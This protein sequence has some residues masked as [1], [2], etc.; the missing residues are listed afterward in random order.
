MIRTLTRNSDVPFC[1]SFMIESELLIL[2]FDKP[3]AQCCILR[4][5]FQ[6]IWLKFCMM[7]PVVRNN[8]DAETKI[9][10]QNWEDLFVKNGLSFVEPHLRPKPKIV[11]VKLAP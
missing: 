7:K 2:G 9:A 6:I 10:M 1:D 3:N 4:Q 5:T 11:E 8:S